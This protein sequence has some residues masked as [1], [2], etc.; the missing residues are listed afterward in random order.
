MTSYLKT[1]CRDKYQEHDLR[2]IGNKDKNRQ[3]G[4][5]HC[6]KL[7]HRN[8]QQNEKEIYRMRENITKVP[9]NRLTSEI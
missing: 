1:D 9:D 5:H 6:K 4:L 8:K 3:V 7:L 2:S